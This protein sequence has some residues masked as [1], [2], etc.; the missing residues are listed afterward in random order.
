MR[1]FRQSYAEINLDH[2]VHNVQMIQRAFPNNPFLCPVIKANA[3]GHGDIYVAKALEKIGIKH[4]GVATIEEASHLRAGGIQ[5]EIL[6]FL[7]PNDSGAREMIELKLTPMLSTWDQL[8]AFEK[9]AKAL[10]TY[11]LPVHLKFNTGMN[12]LGFSAQDADPLYQRLW[13]N[14]F[15]RLAGVATHLHSGDD[16]H[17]PDGSSAEQL[18]GLHRIG[19]VFKSFQVPMHALNSAGVIHRMTIQHREGHP[20]ELH[21]WGLRPGLMIYGYDATEQ[22]KIVLK[23]VMSLKSTVADF[24]FVKK[25]EGVSYS[26][27]WKAV[28]DSVIAVIPIGYADGYHRIL[29]NKGT[30]LFNGREVSLVGT[31][32][33][34]YLMLDV[35]DFVTKE[36]HRSYLD[37]EVVLFGE[38]RLSGSI[39]ADLLARKAQSIAWEIL[40]SVGARIPRVYIGGGI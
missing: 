4:F 14:K 11:A 31:V 1:M 13:Q 6:V 23:P 34:D 12:R 37:A 32:C 29:S 22:N 25:G 9:M 5:S 26:H 33:M 24:R 8:E 30:A 16:A 7:G 35:S 20:L 38:S 28:K 15:L 3:Y 36:N 39:P 10:E 21:D 18:R 40:T 27:T 2:L 19:Q 17:L